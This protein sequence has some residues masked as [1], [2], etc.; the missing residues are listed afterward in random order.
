MPQFDQFLTVDKELEANITRD[1]KKSDSDFTLYDI[2]SQMDEV[3]KLHK[4]ID[5]D[6]SDSDSDEEE[7]E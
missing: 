3:K 2:M 5:Q 6:S 4:F 1:R 7:Y